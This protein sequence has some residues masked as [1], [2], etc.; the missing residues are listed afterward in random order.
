MINQGGGKGRK[1]LGSEVSVQKS[2]SGNQSIH[3]NGCQPS[4]VDLESPR[5]SINV[6]V[7]SEKPSL[8]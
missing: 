7:T 5:I 4:E 8:K 1:S 6:Q 2:L 3:S